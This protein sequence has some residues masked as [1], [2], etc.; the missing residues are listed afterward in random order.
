MKLKKGMRPLSVLMAVLL[1]S[2]VML[3]ARNPGMWHQFDPNA[4]Q[5]KRVMTSKNINRSR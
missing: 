4:A 2:T 3:P 1:V 5:D